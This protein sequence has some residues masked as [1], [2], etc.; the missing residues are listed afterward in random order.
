MIPEQPTIAE[1]PEFFA[2]NT[3]AYEPVSIQPIS[4]VQGVSRNSLYVSRAGEKVC[5]TY[6]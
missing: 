2:K 5:K 6:C 3:D 1:Y 4:S